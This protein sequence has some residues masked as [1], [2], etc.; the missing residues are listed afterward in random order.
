MVNSKKK[1]LMAAI[2]IIFAVLAI[3]IGGGVC[4]F[5]QSARRARPS[6]HDRDGHVVLGRK[7]GRKRYNALYR[8]GRRIRYGL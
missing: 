2:V 7:N 5:K 3:T 4:I 6:E 1:S 8:R